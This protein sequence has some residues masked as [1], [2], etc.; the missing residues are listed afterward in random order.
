[1]ANLLDRIVCDYQVLLKIRN[2][3]E[4]K[5]CKKQNTSNMSYDTKCHPGVYCRQCIEANHCPTCSGHEKPIIE[6]Y[7]LIKQ[8]KFKCSLFP[9]GCQSILP[10][11]ELSEHEKN[12]SFNNE[13][14]SNQIPFKFKPFIPKAEMRAESRFFNEPSFSKQVSFSPLNANE[15]KLTQCLIS[16]VIYQGLIA[17]KGNSSPWSLQNKMKSQANKLKTLP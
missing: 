2:C 10:I 14:K 7:P 16:D 6:L 11:E 5:Q 3:C 13:A 12:C 17:L 4:C 1:M 9:N 15:D 8:A